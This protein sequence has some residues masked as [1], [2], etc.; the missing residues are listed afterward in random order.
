M[1]SEQ[2]E[3]LMDYLSCPLDDVV[4]R[5]KRNGKNSFLN[6]NNLKKKEYKTNFFKQKELT[7]NSSF[8][9]RGRSRFLNRRSGSFK[10]PY[11]SNRFSNS[12]YNNYKSRYFYSGSRD[13]FKNRANSYSSP[14]GYDN[15]KTPY[16]KNFISRRSSINH[17]PGTVFRG[18]LISNKTRK[19][20]KNTPPSRTIISQKLNSYKTVQVPVQK[21][22]NV[23]ISLHRKNR[24]FA[25]SSNR[26]TTTVTPVKKSN[27]STLN[28]SKI[29]RKGTSKATVSAGTRKSLN[30]SKFKP[31]NKYFLSKIKIV[32][33]LNKIPSP[34]K[35]QK[36]TE[37]NLPESLNNANVRKG[38]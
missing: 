23:N 4:D 9:G 35:E 25:M 38:D 28:K 5:E 20:F 37:V 1:K 22:N 14:Y 12:N 8:R 24:T 15:Q 29:I 11:F 6:V 33:S 2:N 27:V 16:N 7:Q 10:K 19:I 3:K 32:T 36:D 13:Y 21:F 30:G 17:T 26:P 31:L 18:S 34:L